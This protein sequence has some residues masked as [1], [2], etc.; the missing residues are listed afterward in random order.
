M[1]VQQA[2]ILSQLNLREMESIVVT[3]Q[4]MSVSRQ[5]TS[6]IARLLSSTRG[7]LQMP[8]MSS[9]TPCLLIY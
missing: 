5:Y 7:D 1:S 8:R 3:A 6:G 4:H 9:S 2:K